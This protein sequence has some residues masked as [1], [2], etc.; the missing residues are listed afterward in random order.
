[1]IKECLNNRILELKKDLLYYETK[2]EFFKEFQSSFA[3]ARADL[4]WAVTELKITVC[5]EIL[6]AMKLFKGGSK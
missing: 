3:Y 1:M 2:K 4:G 5:E 6:R